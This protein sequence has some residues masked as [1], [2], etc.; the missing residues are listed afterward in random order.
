MSV[1]QKP[2]YTDSY[3]LTAIIQTQQSIPKKYNPRDYLGGC[4]RIQEDQAASFLDDF[5]NDIAVILPEHY[6]LMDR[7]LFVLSLSQ[8][9]PIKKLL[10]HAME[11][12]N[13]MMHVMRERQIAANSVK[14]VLTANGPN[15]FNIL[16]NKKKMLLISCTD[17]CALGDAINSE[18]GFNTTKIK[19]KFY[20]FVTYRIELVLS[21]KMPIDPDFN[22]LLKKYGS[23]RQMDLYKK[24]ISNQIK[25]YTPVQIQPAYKSQSVAQSNPHPKTPTAKPKARPVTHSGLPKKH[26][27]PVQPKQKKSGIGLFKKIGKGIKNAFDKIKK[28]LIIGGIFA[29]SIFGGKRLY[30]ASVQQNAKTAQTETTINKSTNVQKTHAINTYD[31]LRVNNMQPVA[32][33]H[34]TPTNDVMKRTVAQL[35]YL[36]ANNPIDRNMDVAQ[37]ANRLYQKFGNDASKVVLASA[38]TP[39]ALNDYTKFDIRPSTH[40]MIE[41]L[42]THE[43][44]PAQRNAL[45]K[46]IA[47]HVNNNSINMN[48]FAAYNA[49]LLMQNQR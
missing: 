25:S 42:C 21:G 5:V 17:M 39:Y 10:P 45:D 23:V 14:P 6:D 34:A 41:Y 36:K 20:A 32:N 19:N 11:K 7:L 9:K 1:Q 44:T 38:M 29:L 31:S 48:D 18:H 15:K 8:Y 46:F 27:H 47:K 49:N 13:A 43:L 24:I 37:T 16:E 28:P 22:V 2:Y 12:Y 4:M 3:L 30:D 35:Q 26:S 33:N 40:N